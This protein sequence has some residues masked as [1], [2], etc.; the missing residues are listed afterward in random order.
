MVSQC[1][2]TA[3]GWKKSAKKF[4]KGKKLAL[5][6]NPEAQCKL[7][8]YYKNGIGVSK[9]PMLAYMWMHLSR[10]K[11]QALKELEEIITQEQIVEALNRASQ[12]KDKKEKVDVL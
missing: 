6:G 3:I 7:G 8:E 1:S 11:P 5:H 10:C 2:C 9:P 12:W 4:S